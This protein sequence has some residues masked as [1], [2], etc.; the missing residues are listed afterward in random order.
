MDVC[1]FGG[2]ADRIIFPM[3]QASILAVAGFAC[4]MHTS[5]MISH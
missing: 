3:L 2:D 4:S 5:A 1:D